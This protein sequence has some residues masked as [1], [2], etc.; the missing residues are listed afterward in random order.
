MVVNHDWVI[1][2]NGF[3]SKSKDVS[4]GKLQGSVSRGV[5]FTIF[6][7]DFNDKWKYR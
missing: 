3:L 4:K 1:I 5:L 6:I 7:N 2:M